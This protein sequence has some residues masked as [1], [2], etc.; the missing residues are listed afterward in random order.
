MREIVQAASKLNMYIDYDDNHELYIEAAAWIGTP[1]NME[2]HPEMALTVLL[3]QK[4]LSKC[5]S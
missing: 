4:N 3:L 2:V 5:I 1:I